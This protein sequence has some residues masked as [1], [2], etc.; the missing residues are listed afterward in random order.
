LDAKLT[1]LLCE[2]GKI[3]VP[4][5]KEVKT[6]CSLAESSKEGCGSKRVALPVMIY[7]HTVAR[8]YLRNMQNATN[9]E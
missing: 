3:T 1:T 5:C 4:K 2:K 9:W 8:E 7:Y 6:G